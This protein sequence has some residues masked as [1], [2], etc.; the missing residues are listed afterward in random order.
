M[1]NRWFIGDTR[2]NGIIGE[3]I[4]FNKGLLKNAPLFLKEVANCEVRGEVYMK[5]EEFLRL[6]EELKKSGHKLLANPRN[7]A[8]G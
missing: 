2:G 3:D 1:K 5:K 6:N 8:A 7:A 4:T